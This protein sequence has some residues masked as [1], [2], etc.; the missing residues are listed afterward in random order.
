LRIG[1]KLAPQSVDF[2]TLA[3]AWTAAGESAT[4][5]SIWSFD[6]LYP[7]AGRGACLEGWTT[8]AVLAH[9]SGPKQIG[10]LVLAA[11]YRN[12]SLLAKMATVMDH[13]TDGR[14]VLGLGAGWHLKEAE[15]F[16][17]PMPSIGDRMALLEATLRSLRTL[18]SSPHVDWDPPVS[19]RLLPFDVPD[20]A[21]FL[22]PPRTPGGPPIWLG[23]SGEQVGLRLVAR[24]ADG[25][26]FSGA[27]GFE[28]DTY[29]RKRDLLRK[30]AAEVGRDGEDIAV[31]VQLKLDGDEAIRQTTATSIALAEAGCSHLILMVDPNEGSAG[32]RRAETVARMVRDGGC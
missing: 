17:L 10:H 24:Y 5:D 28:L 7:I 3:N 31:T 4:L 29:K 32:V 20:A 22:P 19:R 30:Y 9:R 16:G 12:A 6:H 21:V 13:A 14:F 2:L 25:W 18:W 11:P 27:K 8:L 26:N 23:T 1:V 15:D